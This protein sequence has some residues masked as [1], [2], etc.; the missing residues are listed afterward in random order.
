VASLAA[1][2]NDPQR[3]RLGNPDRNTWTVTFFPRSADQIF[4]LTRD[5]DQFGVRFQVNHRS[6]EHQAGEIIA[7]VVIYDLEEQRK[8]LE[9]VR[10]QLSESRGEAFEKLVLARGP[11]PD[12]VR[13]RMIN[14]IDS[15]KSPEYVAAKM[16]ELDVIPGRGQKWTPKKVRKAVNNA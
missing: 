16:N 3:T 6:A 5:L 2:L 14:S 10:D 8:L 7:Y 12:D 9:L 15:G 13:E 11:I 1:A 4:R